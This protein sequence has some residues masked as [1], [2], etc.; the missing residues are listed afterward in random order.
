[1]KPFFFLSLVVCL[2]SRTLV[3]SQCTFTA[4]IAV[5]GATTGCGNRTLTANTAGD[6]WTQKANFGTDNRYNATAFS[7]GSKGYIGTGYDQNTS[8]YKND[9]WEYNPATNVWTQKANFGGSARY[10][11]VGFSIGAK[12]YIGTGRDLNIA[13]CADF[14]EY[15]PALNTWTA[16]AVLPA[17]ARFRA[18]GFSLNGKGYL[19]TGAGPSGLND[20]YE[21]TPS[22]NTWAQKANFPGS[23]R[24]SAVAFAV[25]SK[26]YIGTG[27]TGAVSTNDLWEYDATLDTWTARANMGAIPVYGAVAFAI[28]NNG[29]V[30]TGL[31]TS[32]AT[33]NLWRYTPATNSWVQLQ[34]LGAANVRYY[35]CGFSTGG[36]GYV[37]TSD[38]SGSV[39]SMFE[40]EPQ[41]T[42]A[43]SS[44]AFTRSISVSGSISYSV[45]ITTAIGC[46]ASASQALLLAPDP[47]IS[48]TGAS[49]SCL[50]ISNTLTAS[51]AGT[52][53]WSSNAGG[54]NSA[55]VILNP[56]V[57]T[58]YTVSGTSGTCTVNYVFPLYINPVPVATIAVSGSTLG[59]GIR[60]LS[61]NSGGNSWTQV[62]GLNFGRQYGV[63][64]NI[65]DKGYMGTGYNSNNSP[66]YSDDFWEYDPNANTWTQKANFP[67]GPRAYAV[68]FGIGQKGYIGTGHDLNSNAIMNDFWQFDPASNTWLQR[69]NAGTSQRY[70]ATGFS[71][72][73][74][75]YIGTGLNV[76]T[77]ASLKDFWE[78]DPSSDTWSQQAFVG[79]P[80]RYAAA[81]FTAGGKGYIGT[82][83]QLSDGSK[84]DLWEYDPSLGTWTQKASY[85]AGPAYEV[86]GMS[87]GSKGYFCTGYDVTTSNSLWEYNPSSNTWTQKQNYGGAPR[88]GASAFTIGNKAYLGTGYSTT[89]PNFMND[90]WR[91]DPA[92]TVLWSNSSTLSSVAVASSGTYS[93]TL[94]N[95]SGCSASGVQSLS[96]S[97]NPTINVTGASSV[98][99]AGSVYTLTASGAS[100]YTWSPN[101]GGAFSASIAVTP[102]ALT[103]YTLSGIT[104]TCTVNY[105]VLVDV[106]AS[107]VFAISGPTLG[108]GTLTLNTNAGGNTWTQKANFATTRDF[109]VAFSIGNKGYIGTGRNP[110]TVYEDLWE[111]DASAD[112]WTQKAN[113]PGGPRYFATALSI[114]TKGYVG[115]GY[116][117]LTGTYTNDFWEFDPFANTWLQKANM[118]TVGRFHA[119]A[120]GIGSKGYLGTGAINS[121]TFLKDF[122]EYDPASDTWT[123]KT[124]LGGAGR[125]SARGFS[126]GNKGYL[127]MGSSG[128]PIDDLWEYDPATNLWTQKA[129]IGNGGV[130]TPVAFSIGNKGYIG[131]G[132]NN[133]I[134]NA[135][136]EYDPS[137]NTWTQKSNMGNSPRTAAVGFAIGDKGY[138][139]TGINYPPVAY[140]NDFWQYSPES[141]ILWSNSASV[142]SITV[143][144][145]GIYSATVTNILGCSATQSRSVTVFPNPTLTVSGINSICA[146]ASAGFTVSG[147]TTYTWSANAGNAVAN[148]ISVSPSGSTIYSVTGT[149][150]SCTASATKTLT[151]NAL[152]NVT[153]NSSTT[154]VCEG[155]TISLNGGGANTYTW[156]GGA[157]NNA[158][159]VP[160]A[161]ASYT[162]TGTDLN[163]CSNT[164]TIAVTVN[165][166]PT[167]S[168][169]SGSICALQSF[170]F[171][172]SGALTYS[173][174]GG[175]SIVSPNTTSNYTVTGYD[176]LGCNNISPA[177]ST[178]TVY[179]LPVIPAIS[180]VICAGNSFIIN[181]TGASSYT[182][183]SGSAT[184]TPS[185]NTSYSVTGISTAGCLSAGPSLVSITVSALPFISVNS[186]SLCEGQGFTLSPTGASTYSYSGGSAIVS[187]LVN[188]SYSV[189][190]YNSDGC[191]GAAVAVSTIT[192]YGSPTVS[193][194]SGTICQGTSF[195]IVPTGALSYS[196]SSGSATVIPNSTATF[197]TT[198]YN[199]LGCPNAAPAI[200]TVTVHALPLIT[201]SST[202]ICEGSSYTIVP[203]GANS[204]TYS[205][206]SAIVSPAATS[207]YSV[208]GTSTAGCVSAGPTIVQVTVSPLPVV[209][210]SDGTICSGQNFTLSPSGAFTYSYSGG[211]ALVSP[212]T[213]TFYLITG[214]N[215]NGCASA[216]SATSSVTVLVSPT[217]TAAGG[218]ICAG[219]SFTISPSGATNYTI[220]GNTFTVNPAST[221]TYTLSGTNAIGCPGNTVAVNVTIDTPTI[222]VNSGSICSGNSF[223]LVPTGGVN[224]SVSGNIFTV[225]PAVSTTYTV[226]G[227]SALGCSG[228]TAT[229]S[230]TV[231]SLPTISVN[232]GSICAGNTFTLV[233]SGGASYSV[234]GNTFTVS[235]LTNAFYTVTGIS[236]AGCAGNTA[237]ASIT[238]YSSPALAINS[239]SVCAGSPFVILPSGANAYTI[240]GGSYTVN[241]ASTS[242]Y[243]LSGSNIQGCVSVISNT[244]VVSPL[245]LV[246]AST[247]APLLCSG[248][249]AV[250]T[251]SGANTFT[252]TNLQ[253]GTSITVSPLTTTTY[254]VS[255]TNLAG[256][257]NTGSIQQVVDDCTSLKKQNNQLTAFSIY[258]N[259]NNGSFIVEAPENTQILVMTVG[260]EIILK[261]KIRDFQTGFSIAGFSNGI[262]FVSFRWNDKLQTF[263][264]IKE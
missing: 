62:A 184:V 164:A 249:S 12:G 217:L 17:Q 35:A 162:V 211:S 228:N 83:I 137:S 107:P 5:S 250:L 246:T 174:S 226:T 49:L 2:F 108:C 163:A 18:V 34:S 166:G 187:P 181:P 21:Y 167:V 198:G 179:Q 38:N 90:L 135:L 48:V 128:S 199:A 193:V 69:S 111:Y 190:G 37:G 141:T 138:I 251:A 24:S 99:C 77:S 64:F 113:V 202:L 14:W 68:G 216:T 67:P 148:T 149:A 36:K 124:N 259:P 223:T 32:G 127:G 41:V 94:I 132:D 82:G 236:S 26:G 147:A 177:I 116:S 87:I 262:Y 58:I 54:G 110:G 222:A 11:A 160:V 133:V 165:P 220:S 245:P 152:P 39:S 6:A 243:T 195:I 61:I 230:I 186:G 145:P 253:N 106:R 142:Q 56:A 239:G 59:C 244:V 10:G 192:V 168:V 242:S 30:S 237:T 97:P 231:Y 130:S 29:Y 65:G 157:I 171:V 4:S 126:I 134:T 248:E 227:T 139:G 76:N 254:Y 256:C 105:P 31:S 140:L 88:R 206:G 219:Q 3:F 74:K 264:I 146:G 98:L 86:T 125:N 235:P 191:A 241:P 55:T 100:A 176:A 57:S 52:Y 23:P 47:T 225:N 214:Y 92:A 123:Q 19:G 119:A 63:S 144:T 161:T 156:T 28:G 7:I 213:N 40:Y 50:G 1:M 13:Y 252:W 20:F 102:T 159:F 131:T 224:Y 189:T 15:D 45:L 209:S 53:T 33:D 200:T 208:S 263:K 80:T 22:T 27:T 66:T 185:A 109:A 197:T 154:S 261:E 72:L 78:Y 115:T 234:S 25:G 153:A 155:H 172:P 238:V 170:T 43:W 188:T 240:S 182:Y 70:Q 118:G 81:S 233:P 121:N 79:G 104:G 51:G 60:T 46:T 255:G 180:T 93:V 151:V 84:D 120:F 258:P 232:S 85:P 257:T 183:S 205:N 204:Y 129:G 136:W 112:A 71:L 75:G 150:N 175:T 194:N 178:V 247:S 260:G 229:A 173:Y 8:T 158:S 218:T 91:Y 44:G 101:A 42:Y 203:S 122:W 73:G 143:N 96:L 9:F 16:R 201:A 196:Y 95:S 169:N 215:S 103:I 210:V 117:V 114:G 212:L 207:S 89:L 221:T